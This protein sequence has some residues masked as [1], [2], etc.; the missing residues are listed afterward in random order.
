MYSYDSSMNKVKM[1]MVRENYSEPGWKE[2][3]KDWLKKYWW[4]VLLIAV[5]IILLFVWLVMRKRKPS[6]PSMGFRRSG[7]RF[8]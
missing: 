1:G 6:T 5:V 7:Y 2:K 8:Y 3:A 4:V